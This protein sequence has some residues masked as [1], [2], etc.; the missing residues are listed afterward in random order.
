MA[1][2]QAA[3]ESEQQA[4]D[5]IERFADLGGKCFQAPHDGRGLPLPQLDGQ[6]RRIS[7]VH[8]QGIVECQAMSRDDFGRRHCEPGSGVVSRTSLREWPDRT[9]PEAR[10]HGCRDPA[11]PVRRVGAAL[12]AGAEVRPRTARSEERIARKAPVFDQVAGKGAQ[13]ADVGARMRG[14]AWGR[15][16]S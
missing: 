12:D 10:C 5:V 2:I 15:G 13:G 1:R 3:P 8:A 9:G 11:R 6:V 4:I 7:I 16:G 14:R